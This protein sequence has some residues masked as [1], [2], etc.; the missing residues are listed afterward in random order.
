MENIHLR[1]SSSLGGRTSPVT[2]L[3]SADSLESNTANEKMCLSCYNSLD[4][5]DVICFDHVETSSNPKKV[6]L[7]KSALHMNLILFREHVLYSKN[8][9]QFSTCLLQ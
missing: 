9:E 7:S 5:H 1:P 6:P 2:E 4:G 3:M 8:P